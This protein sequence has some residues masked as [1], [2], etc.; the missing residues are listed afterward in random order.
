MPNAHP[1]PTYFQ[2][3]GGEEVEGSDPQ[4]QQLEIQVIDVLQLQQGFGEAQWVEG[5]PYHEAKKEDEDY[6]E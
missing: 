6:Q 5:Q 3:E 1:G 4:Q 2:H